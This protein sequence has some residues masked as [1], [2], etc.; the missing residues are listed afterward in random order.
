MEVANHSSTN[1][2]KQPKKR[3][4]TRT[5]ECSRVEWCVYTFTNNRQ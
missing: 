4:R 3:S 5:D 2:T 1:T